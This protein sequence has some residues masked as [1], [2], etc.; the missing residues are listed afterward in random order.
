MSPIPFETLARRI[1]HSLEVQGFMKL[2]GASVEEVVPGRVVLALDRRPEVL[3]QAGLFHGGVIAFLI[4][5]GATAAGATVNRPGFTVMTAE[6]KV[7]IVSPARG[8]RLVC[9]SDVVKPG[10]MLTV[11]ESKVFSVEDGAEKLVAVA[12]AGIA[13]VE[14]RAGS[15][16]A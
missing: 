5:N 16:A 15:A 2:V 7:N 13:N 4:D 6:Y 10:R 11:V 8:S 3:Q 12:L 14:E 9:R 1:R